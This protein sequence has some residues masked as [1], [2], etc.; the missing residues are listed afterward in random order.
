MISGI[1]GR[2]L[3]D[4]TSQYKARDG[5]G[6][7]K[8]KHGK[9]HRTF[10][11]DVGAQTHPQQDDQGNRIHHHRI[12]RQD[13]VTG[14]GAFQQPQHRQKLRDRDSEAVIAEDIGTRVG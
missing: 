4:I 1:R 8:A 14:I 3:N 5:H 7:H 11:I 13:T 2:S 9:D 6:R 12:Q 10:K